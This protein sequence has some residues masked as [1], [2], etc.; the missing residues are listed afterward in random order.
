MKILKVL[1]EKQDEMPH[2]QLKDAMF[3][4]NKWDSVE[5]DDSDDEES[6]ETEKTRTYNYIM[7]HLTREWRDVSTE[8][9]FQVCLK[10]VCTTFLTHSKF[11]SNFKYFIKLHTDFFR[12]KV[13]NALILCN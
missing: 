6:R 9:V 2:F 7:E 1:V 3:L 10:M 4:T 11:G 5:G 12:E 8:N 13:Q